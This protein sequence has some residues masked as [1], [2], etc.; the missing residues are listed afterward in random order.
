MEAGGI[1]AEK[2]L[3]HTCAHHSN[4][5]VHNSGGDILNIRNFWGHARHFAHKMGLS[6]SIKRSMSL[7]HS[8]ILVI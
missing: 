4:P 2:P 3:Y 8:N 1:G 7:L 6:S 5:P